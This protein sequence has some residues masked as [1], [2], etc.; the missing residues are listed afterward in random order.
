MN[1]KKAAGILAVDIVASLLLGISI[2]VFTVS[3]NFAPGG[4]SGVAVILNEWAYRVGIAPEHF[5]NMFYIS[6]YC[7]PH[8]PVYSLIQPIVPFPWSLVLY[9]L[10]FTVAASVP[11]ALSMGLNKTEKSTA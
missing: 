4:V 9:I 1:I 11:V 10:G 8:L 5:F 6:P 7:A 2:V 3:A